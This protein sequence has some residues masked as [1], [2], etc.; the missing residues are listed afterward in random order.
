MNGRSERCRHRRER[1]PHLGCEV[2]VQQEILRDGER[3][4]PAIIARCRNEMQLDG[5][6]LVQGPPRAPNQEITA[7]AAK[8]CPRLACDAYR[9]V[10]LIL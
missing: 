6:S 5:V 4:V 1:G 7:A 2:G 8:L 3:F 9:G 10:G